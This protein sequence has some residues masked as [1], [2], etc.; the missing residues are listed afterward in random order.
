MI[1]RMAYIAMTGAKNA[2][3]QLANTSNNLANA[4][5]PGFREMISAFRTVPLDGQSA[6]SRAFV[7][8]STPGANFA[9][10]TIETTGN[11][12]DVAIRQDGFFAVRRE[13]EGGEITIPPGAEMQI[14]KDGG[15][16]A[17]AAGETRFNQIG[18]LKLVN[19]DVRT[20]TRAGDGLFEL[21]GGATA[22]KAETVEVVQGA[23]E[24]SNV[25]V[26]MAM[27]QMINQS[28]MFDLNMK[29]ITTAD[30]NSRSANS[31]MSLSRG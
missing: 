24:T 17:K 4:Q 21:P 12:F 13:D 1:D 9:P 8:D 27:V 30:Q 14:G 15:I 26:S 22:D 5:T 20:L 2:M 3:G 11:P 10:G 29:L 31:L 16:F 18:Q 25:N 23:V 19:P 6:D 7:V 28:R